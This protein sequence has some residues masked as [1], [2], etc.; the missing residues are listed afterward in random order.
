MGLNLA[1]ESHSQGNRLAEDSALAAATAAAAAAAAAE[2]V[3]FVLEAW[4]LEA[5]PP[6]LNFST[7][8]VTCAVSNMMKE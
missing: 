1:A 4:P 6:L 7:V 2:P 8:V 3:G 5:E